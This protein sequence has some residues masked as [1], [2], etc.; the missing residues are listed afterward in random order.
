MDPV[1]GAM[2]VGGGATV[3]GGLMGADAQNRARRAA[4]EAAARGVAQFEG[5]DVPTVAEQSLI[6]QTP[7]LVGTYD[8]LLEQILSLGPSAM[9][10]VSTDPLLAQAQLDSLLGLQDIAQGGLT[11]ADMAASRDIQRQVGQSSEARRQ[12][13]LQNM[14]ERGVL[15]S[16]MELAAQLQGEQ[17]ATDQQAKASD[18]LIRQAQA[19][20][21]QGLTAS[22]NMASQ[23][24]TQE[25]G[26][27]SDVARAQDIINQF[28]TANQQQTQQRNVA[29]QNRAQ[30]ANLL[31]RQ[32]QE[33]QRAQLANQQQQ[34]NKQLIQQQYQNQ[35][36]L[37]RARA[38]AYAGQG[39]I[40]NQAGQQQA[41]QIG[42]IAS[43]I[44]NIAGAYM[45]AQNQRKQAG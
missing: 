22:G 27:K 42:G 40:Q 41:Q 21:L 17:Q 19:R 38:N 39:Q 2:L 5:I 23:M 30:Q 36:D 1:T 12:A 10:G 7:D 6:L 8:P 28:N 4:L 43:G 32:A 3:I 33:D 15:G 16:G 26:E 34:Y 13:I 20:A 31:A 9:E 18:E 25:F 35:M 44:A 24:R 11:E 29:E 14:A 37:A 45:G